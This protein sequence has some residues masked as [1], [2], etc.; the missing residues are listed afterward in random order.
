MAGG[1]A[2]VYTLGAKVGMR[3]EFFAEAK[4]ILIWGSN[5][6]ASNL[7]FWRHA[8]AAKRAGARLAFGGDARTALRHRLCR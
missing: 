5:S 1:E 4:L 8:Q 7:H 3:I 6:I 2:M